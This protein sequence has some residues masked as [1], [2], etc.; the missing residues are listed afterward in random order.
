MK[1]L[2]I[3]LLITALFA[4]ASFAAVQDFGAFTV[5]VPEGWT[6]TQDGETVGIV[7][8]DNSAAVSISYDSTDGASAQELAEAF[9]SALNGR[10]LQ[11]GNNAFTFAMTNASGVESTCY[12]YTENEKYALVVVTG[13]E[14]APDEVDAIVGSLK[15]KK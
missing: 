11:G 15:D 12:L 6:A 14:N 7:K 4:A 2:S 13:K 3:A 8:N 1:R 5:D 10:D 9:V